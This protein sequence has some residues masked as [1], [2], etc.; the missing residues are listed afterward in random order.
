MGCDEHL[1]DGP[2]RL[3]PAL[4]PPGSIPFLGALPLDCKFLGQCIYPYI[5]GMGTWQAL[6][7]CLLNLSEQD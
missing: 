6:N 5:P 3:D 7:T 2:I 4:S 1:G